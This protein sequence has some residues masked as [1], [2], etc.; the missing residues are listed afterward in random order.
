M[1]ELIVALFSTPAMSAVFSPRAHVRCMLQFEAALARAEARAGVIPQQA[2]S[3]IAASCREDSSMSRPCTVRR[4][5]LAL[6]LSPS[7]AC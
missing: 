1:G 3:A 2:A 6:P 7:C 4:W 5:W